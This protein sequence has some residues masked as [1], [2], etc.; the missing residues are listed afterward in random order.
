MR[1]LPASFRSGRMWWWTFAAFIAV[2]ACALALLGLRAARLERIE[3]QQQLRDQQ[4]QVTRLADAAIA[5]ALARLEGAL[6]RSETV[7]PKAAAPFDIPVFSLDRRGLVLFPKERVYFGEFG[8][9]PEFMPG[10][11]SGATASLVARAQA[12]EVQQRADE[13]FASYSR[14]ASIDPRLRPWAELSLARMR[15][16]RGDGGALAV[17]AR[18]QWSEADGSTPSGLPVALLACSYAERLAP[19]QGRLFTRLLE[20]TLDKLRRGQWWMSYEERSF[21]DAELR[22]LLAL[23]GARVLPADSHLRELAQIERMTQR[24]VPYLRQG[25]TRS[26][27]PAKTGDPPSLLLWAASERNAGSW[28][29]AAIAG[30]NLPAFLDPVLRPLL[31]GQPFRGVLRDAAGNALWSEAAPGPSGAPAIV[32]RSVPG[33]ELSFSTPNETGSFD[34]RRLLWYGFIAALVMMLMVGL[35]MT[36]RVV[37]REMELS[38]LQAEFL[39]AVTHEFKSPIT[40]IRLL[41]ERI[42]AGRLRTPESASEY[43]AAIQQQ[44]DRLERLV[45]RVLECQKI[46]AGRKL[47]VREPASIVRIA[48]GAV[49]RFRP[50][51]EAKNISLGLQ[52]QGD[53][54]EIDLDQTAI[55]DALENLLDNAIKYSSSGTRVTVAIELLDEYVQVSVS[56]QGI[57]IDKDDLPRVWEKFYRSRRG[58]QHN[59]H[60]TGLGLALVKA[61]A[62]GHGGTAEVSSTPGSGSRFTLRL[63]AGSSGERARQ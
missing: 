45:N 49:A 8:K 39:A 32:I 12:A 43:H 22:R 23:A 17:L 59:V 30:P 31:S 52:V 4:A 42:T 41:V 24:A 18:P 55:A 16:E 50:Q 3:R 63:P 35:A 61:A 44:A 57:G 1:F 56:D 27:G 62:E 37:R 15:Y 53:V 13:A 10:E 21:H 46:E 28:A 54:P 58:D 47:Y 29:G 38:R 60:G 14:I 7:S 11:T 20:L 6:A 26:Y 40:S 5:T 33:W 34:Q 48:E 2:P 9:R 19:Q 51:A 36:A 25:I